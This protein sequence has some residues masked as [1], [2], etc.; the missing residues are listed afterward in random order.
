[1]YY[2]EIQR[3][4]KDFCHNSRTFQDF[5]QMQGLLRNLK[6]QDKQS[7]SRAVQYCTNP[8]VIVGPLIL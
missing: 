3:L 1:M 6:F 4:F 8:D 7:N 5:M 2:L